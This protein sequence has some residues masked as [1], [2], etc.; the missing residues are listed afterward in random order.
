[1][2]EQE[3]LLSLPGEG[4]RSHSWQSLNTLIRPG[5]AEILIARSRWP[6]RRSLTEK[7]TEPSAGHGGIRKMGQ[8]AIQ[9]MPQPPGRTDE[10]QRGGKGRAWDRQ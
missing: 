2:W 10:I 5:M 6:G 4:G 9:A 3:L 7:G 1:M 8:E